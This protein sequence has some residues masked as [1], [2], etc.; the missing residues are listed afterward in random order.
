MAKIIHQRPAILI[1]KKNTGIQSEMMATKCETDVPV[2]KTRDMALWCTIGS[3]LKEGPIRSSEIKLPTPWPATR[4]KPGQTLPP[5][6]RFRFIKLTQCGPLKMGTVP[7]V[8]PIRKYLKLH[9]ELNVF[10]MQTDDPIPNPIKDYVNF[11][12]YESFEIEAIVKEPESIAI[13]GSKKKGKKGKGK[14]GKGGKK[15]KKK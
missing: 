10:N 8:L 14:K 9:P 3:N 13:T 7:S 6:G 4:R 11:K 1:T 5:A 15:G 2:Q 12:A